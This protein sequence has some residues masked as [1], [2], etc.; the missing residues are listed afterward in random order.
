MQMGRVGVLAV[1]LTALLMAWPAGVMAQT[2]DSERQARVAA[3]IEMMEAAGSAKQFEQVMPMLSASMT[4]TFTAL[5]PDSA[6]EIRDVM[7]EVVK[8]FSSRKQ[9]M[10]DKIA[11][12]YA[13]EL[14]VDEMKEL[15]RFY[16]SPVGLKFISIQPKMA[17]QT[18]MLGQQWGQSIGRE[19]DQEARR[20]LKKRGVDL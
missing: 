1:V 12:M 8:R 15:T 9:E 10:I 2:G 13:A 16:S 18:I 3:A 6:R 7:N 20:E 14:T 17:Q 19:I 5:R 11:E 4:K